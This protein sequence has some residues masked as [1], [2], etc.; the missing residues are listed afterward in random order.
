M[1]ATIERLAVEL[2][3]LVARSLDR[4]SVC[5]L[6]LASLTLA[7]KLSPF[8]VPWAFA[9]KDVKLDYEILDELIR[10]TRPGGAGCILQHCAVISVLVDGFSKL[11]PPRFLTSVTADEP[12]K[13]TLARLLTHA[14]NNIRRNSSRGG[15]KSLRIDLELQPKDMIEL[16]RIMAARSY[17]PSALHEEALQK[18]SRLVHQAF[19]ATIEALRESH[20]P[21]S[22]HF[23]IFGSFKGFNLSYLD[24]LLPMISLASTTTVFAALRELTMSLSSVHM[25]PIPPPT[26]YSV[27]LTDPGEDWSRS[28]AGQ[29]M[30]HG[31]RFLRGLLVLLQFMPH[32]E[33]LDVCCYDRVLTNISEGATDLGALVTPLEF[34]SHRNLK[35]V[36]LQGLYV[37][38]EALLQYLQAV[39]PTKLIL[40]EIHLVP[41]TWFPIFKYL[42]GSRTTP[43]KSYRLH[44]RT[45]RRGLVEFDFFDC[46]IGGKHT[47]TYTVD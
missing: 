6:R 27:G 24:T 34:P 12:G 29:K 5:N 25:P 7:A 20:L 46:D 45:G 26:T 3:V 15:L 11:T 4:R 21:V 13:P 8:N 36:S 30:L 2:L 38:S 47:D 23:Y 28:G 16:L 39:R 31:S 17:A 22:D 14:F 44:N 18:I 33:E 37:T 9:H 32:L 40:T 10:M 35:V 41:G 43:L 42:S 19:A 1:P